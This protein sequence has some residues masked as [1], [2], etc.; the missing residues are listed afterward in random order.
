MRESFVFDFELFRSFEAALEH[1]LLLPGFDESVQPDEAGVIGEERETF[2]RVTAEGE[3][4]EVRGRVEVG[5]TERK[6]LHDVAKL[7]E[8]PGLQ[9]A[10]WTSAPEV[11]GLPREAFTNFG[12]F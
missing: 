5:R 2:G 11:A 8:K 1:V 4:V 3:D 6:L 10:R 9:D 7:L 12:E